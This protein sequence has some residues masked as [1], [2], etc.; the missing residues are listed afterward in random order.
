MGVVGEKYSVSREF[1]QNFHVRVIAGGSNLENASVQFSTNEGQNFDLTTNSSGLT[2]EVDILSSQTLNITV[3]PDG[4]DPLFFSYGFVLDESFLVCFRAV[5]PEVTGINADPENSF[6]FV[7]WHSATN[8]TVQSGQLGSGTGGEFSPIT[9]SVESLIPCKSSSKI[10]NNYRRGKMRFYCPP[11]FEGDDIEFILNFTLNFQGDDENDV[12]VA[13][14]DN[15]GAQQFVIGALTKTTCDTIDYYSLQGVTWPSIKSADKYWMVIYNTLNENVYYVSNPFRS[16]KEED[17]LCYP[18]LSYRNDCDTF[19]FGYE[20][21]ATRNKIRLDI[22]MVE[23]Q[24][25]IEIDQYRE[26]TTGLLRNEKSQTALVTVVETKQFDDGANL[27]GMFS[28]NTHDDILIN[29]RPYEVK[30]PHR[31]TPNRKNPL[32][33]GVIELYDQ[34][35][36]TVNLT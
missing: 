15:Y 32:Q 10:P 2:D 35:F 7:R 22:N 6:H 12:T 1:T 14:F 34:E 9:A 16:Y 25:E 26:Q 33:D 13:I 29:D 4:G 23:P 21:V 24:A 27:G 5:V 36:S 11:Y 30:T 8:L 28:L 31:V 17:K 18:L 20:C 19:G 3:T